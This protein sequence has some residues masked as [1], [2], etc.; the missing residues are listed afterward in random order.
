MRLL[1]LDQTDIYGVSAVL[2][3]SLAVACTAGSIMAVVGI[4]CFVF[5]LKLMRRQQ[6]NGYESINE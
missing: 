4:V 3:Y 1:I 6:K 2:N 5:G